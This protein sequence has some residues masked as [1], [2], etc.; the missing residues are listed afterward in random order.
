MTRLAVLLSACGLLAATAPRAIQ[1]VN[2]QQSRPAAAPGAGA[3]P[4]AAPAMSIAA[5]VN[6]AA[7]ALAAQ[8]K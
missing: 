8:G 2:A 3:G 1:Q 7:L 5:V 6:A 4:G